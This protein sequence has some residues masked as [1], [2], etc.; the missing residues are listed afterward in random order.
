M[1]CL[2]LTFPISAYQETLERIQPHLGTESVVLDIAT[3]KQNTMD[4]LKATDPSVNFISMHPMFGPESYSQR[5]SDMNGFRVV[6]TGHN[7]VSSTYDAF[8]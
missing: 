4:L 6:I 1:R 5:D 3:V 7:L 2:I 8:C